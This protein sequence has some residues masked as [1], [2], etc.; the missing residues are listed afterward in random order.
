M[1]NHSSC[2]QFGHKKSTL[3]LENKKLFGK[4]LEIST[5]KVTPSYSTVAP[6]CPKAV[7]CVITFNNKQRK[8]R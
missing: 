2:N 1:R 5:R 3:Q 7:S 8:R 4:L 6:H